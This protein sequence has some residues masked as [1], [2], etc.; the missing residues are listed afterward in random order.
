[1]KQ[2]NKEDIKQ[3]YDSTFQYPN[4]D[5]LQGKSLYERRAELAKKLVE[6]DERQKGGGRCGLRG[7]VCALHL[8]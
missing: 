5:G 2:E 7:R 1:M 6:F 8:F 3:E 4:P